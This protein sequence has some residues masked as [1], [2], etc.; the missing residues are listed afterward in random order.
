MHAYY[1]SPLSKPNILEEVRKFSHLFNVHNIHKMNDGQLGD[2]C[3][4]DACLAH[5]LFSTDLEALQ[6]LSSLIHWKL[7]IHW[8][9]NYTK[10]H[11]IG[12]YS[13]TV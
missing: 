12:E 5:P 3:D 11:K 2:Y 10:K 4:G 9:H 1:R 7:R 8:A 13:F 6:I